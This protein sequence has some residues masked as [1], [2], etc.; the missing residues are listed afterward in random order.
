MK[1]ENLI[2]LH[3]RG[4]LTWHAIENRKVLSAP[5]G[6]RDIRYSTNTDNIVNVVRV[7]NILI[8]PF[9]DTTG[10]LR[11]VVHLVNKKLLGE[12]D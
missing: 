12:I 4:G 6:E 2:R 3:S 10:Q 11:G 8:G 9:Y 1:E 7:N 5:L